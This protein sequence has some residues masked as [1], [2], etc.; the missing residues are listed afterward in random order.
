MKEHG[1]LL[2]L[3][4]GGL[5][6]H[7]ITET[8]TLFHR[9]AVLL[10][11]LELV[12]EVL[13]LS[14][15]LDEIEIVSLTLSAPSLGIGSVGGV[16]I[17]IFCGCVAIGFLLGVIFFLVEVLASV[18]VGIVCKLFGLDSKNALRGVVVKVIILNFWRSLLL[19]CRLMEFWKVAQTMVEFAA[20]QEVRH[21]LTKLWTIVLGLLPTSP[22]VEVL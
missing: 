9:H 11:C 13:D 12:L 3:D 16:V 20:G 8:R 14:V 18:W 22:I 5:G 4:S 17:S 21:L 19:S 15:G 2:L 6:T 1:L 7:Q 10:C